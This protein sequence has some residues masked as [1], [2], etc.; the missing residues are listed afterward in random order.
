VKNWLVSN[1]TPVK[2]AEAKAAVIKLLAGGSPDVIGLCEIGNRADVAEIQAMLKAEGTDL[3]FIHHTGGADAVRHLAILSRFP[4]AKVE[5]PDLEIPGTGQSMQ[6]GILDVTL[7]VGDRPIRFLGLHL[8]SKR[9]V[10][11]FDEALLRVQEAGHVRNHIDHIIE[12]D[13]EAMLVVYGDF[14][15]TTRSL[16]TRSIYGTYRTPG[17]MNPIHVKDSRGEAWTYRYQV[18][19]SY[20]RI[21][22]VT[23]SSALKRHVK[24]DKSMVVDE[25][26]WEEA[27]DHRPVLVRFE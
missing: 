5:K 26:L 23:V 10:P 25:P 12:K 18:Q 7:S 9:I 20:S 4:I 8:K 27:S 16:S 2:S 1:Q 17:Y 21:D 19:D 3:P 24:K 22:F 11:E 6:R 14:N 13:E 15:D